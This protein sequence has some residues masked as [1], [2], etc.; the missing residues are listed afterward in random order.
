MTA[1]RGDKR[2][3]DRTARV[4]LTDFGLSHNLF[5]GGERRSRAGTFVG[6]PAYLAPEVLEQT[7]GYGAPADVW[8]LG[9]TLIEMATGRSPYAGLPPLK[10]MLH[11]LQVRGGQ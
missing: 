2:C 5:E 8:S 7:A 11:V 1:G 6:T 9:I 3:G 4:R 10:I